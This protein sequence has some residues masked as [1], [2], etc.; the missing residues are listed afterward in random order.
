MVDAL[1]I[2]IGAGGIVV[3]LLALAGVYFLGYWRA[4]SPDN[5]IDMQE[6]HNYNMYT[7]T[8]QAMRRENRSAQTHQEHHDDD[9]GDDLP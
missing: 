7:D 1:S 3:V 5:I 4:R 9:G 2:A 8:E 6:V